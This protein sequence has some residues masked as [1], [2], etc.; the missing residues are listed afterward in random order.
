MEDRVI[1]GL[2]NSAYEPVVSLTVRGRSGQSSEIKAIVDTGFSEF[3]TLPP[4]LVEEL[5]LP[6][7]ASASAIL[8]D[9]SEVTF[10]VYRVTILWDDNP[11]PVH[12]YMS[13]AAPLLGM[14]LLDQHNL[15][16]EVTDGGR[17]VIQAR[18]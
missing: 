10:E 1:Q 15:N 4:V 18:D 6:S 12:A 3:L 17:V 2:V 5:K 16:I 7:V 11:R 14:R 13:D 8:A 9:G